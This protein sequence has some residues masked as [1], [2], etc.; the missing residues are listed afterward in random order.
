V[1]SDG[2]IVSARVVQ[3]MDEV[4]FFSAGGIALRLRV[5][6]IPQQGRGTSGVRLVQL[7]A[8]DSV[9]VVARLSDLPITETATTTFQA[10]ES[11]VVTDLLPHPIDDPAAQPGDVPVAEEEAV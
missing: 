10:S 6:D 4:A 3:P 9:A 11:T 1:A 2:R 7:K 5:K 8:G